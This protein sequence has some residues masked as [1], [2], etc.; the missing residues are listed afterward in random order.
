MPGSNI[1]NYYHE[2]YKKASAL[3]AD[4]VIS[5]GAIFN[6]GFLVLNSESA[7]GEMSA[8]HDN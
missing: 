3:G 6:A 1:E 7:K 5:S 2:L 8:A 4:P